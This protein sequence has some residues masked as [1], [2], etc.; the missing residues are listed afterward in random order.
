MKC[1]KI[2][3]TPFLIFMSKVILVVFT[4]CEQKSQKYYS[5]PRIIFANLLHL[6]SSPKSGTHESSFCLFKLAEAAITR[7]HLLVIREKFD[8]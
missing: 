2:Y 4:G 7:S 3:V 6:L 8:E 1:D 5:L